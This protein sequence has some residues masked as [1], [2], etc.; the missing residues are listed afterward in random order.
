MVHTFENIWE[1]KSNCERAGFG[2]RMKVWLSYLILSILPIPM[3]EAVT[4]DNKVDFPNKI[5]WDL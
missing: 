3:Q 1:G 5:N 4:G 2:R